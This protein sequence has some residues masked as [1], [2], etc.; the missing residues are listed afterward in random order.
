MIM[1]FPL[2]P[3]EYTYKDCQRDYI[4]VMA[5]LGEWAKD[6]AIDGINIDDGM[7]TVFYA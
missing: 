6:R 4:M 3:N 1:E 5:A 7:Y 2:H